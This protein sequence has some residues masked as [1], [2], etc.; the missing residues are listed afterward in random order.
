MLVIQNTE[1]LKRVFDLKK[2][3]PDLFK[4]QISYILPDSEKP[5]LPFVQNIYMISDRLLK[6][7]KAYDII[8]EMGN[9][10][11][12]IICIIF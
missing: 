8:D 4:G 2:T 1:I 6:E 11:M 10:F 12:T 7:L 3:R 9:Y 5:V